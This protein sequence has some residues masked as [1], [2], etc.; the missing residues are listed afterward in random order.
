MIGPWRTG[1]T[2][3]PLLCPN[4]D[5]VRRELGRRRCAGS[6]VVLVH[7]LPPVSYVLKRK[8]KEV[9]KGSKRTAFRALVS[10]GGVAYLC[11]PSTRE[12]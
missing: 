2:T 5:K 10:D 4:Y 7:S 12:L 1:P 9:A 6:V 11:A 3:H 8:K